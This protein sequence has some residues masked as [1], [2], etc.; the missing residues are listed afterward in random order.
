MS[1][2]LVTG[3]AGMIGSHI[4][5]RLIEN[6]HDTFGVDDL[7]GGARENVPCATK[8]FKDDIGDALAMRHVFTV[9][10]PEFVINCAAFAAE[11]LSH[12]TRVFTIENNLAGEAVVRNHCIEWDVKCMVSLSS[13]AVMGHQE[14]PFHDDT[15]PAPRDP[16]GIMKYAGELDAR[17]AFE[18]HGLNYCVVRPHNVLGT[19]QNYSD[20]YR[21]VAAIFI[22]RALENKPLTIFG[23]G[24]QTRAF[25][26]VSYVSDVIART[27]DRPKCWNQAFNV[28]CEDVITVRELAHLVILVSGQKSD[29]QY[30]PARK[31]ACHAHMTHRICA[32]LF[33]DVICHDSIVTALQGMIG[34]ARP[35][36]FRPMQRGPRIEVT[37]G[38][39]ESWK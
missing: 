20:R 23:D 30:L 1:R 29:I 36:S 35:K 18:F 11:N 9:S 19:R 13:I 31:E 12:N 22:R 27:I 14:P 4:C 32:D 33:G 24:E 5:D 15:P 28:G 10:S 2:V 38:L 17:A 16:Y 8:F 6:G 34:E 7:S 21:N 26:P 39:P 25:S 37:K 3:C